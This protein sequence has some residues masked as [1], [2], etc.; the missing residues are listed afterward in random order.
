MPTRD[1]LKADLLNQ[2]FT[3]LLVLER[4][5]LECGRAVWKCLCDCGEVVYNVSRVLLIGRVKSCGCLSKETTS[6]R[7]STHKATNTPEHNTWEALRQ[8]CNNKN[9]LAYKYYGERGITICPEWNDFEIFLVDMGSKSSPKHSIERKD[10]SKGY[11]K[12][13]CYWATHTAQMNNTR[14]NRLLTLNGRTQSLTLWSR[15]INIKVPTLKRRLNSGWSDED[16]LTVP[17]QH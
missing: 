10:N 13:N 2:R 15:E 6:I 11:S 1:F 14:Q 3:R 8:R 16:V 4:T 12:D 9:H 17:L 7:M 5:R